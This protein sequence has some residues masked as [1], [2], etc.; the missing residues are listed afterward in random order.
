MMLL[1]YPFEL[2]PGQE[3]CSRC[4]L[5]WTDALLNGRNIES[6]RGW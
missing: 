4:E 2:P 6:R 1:R 3:N 5:F